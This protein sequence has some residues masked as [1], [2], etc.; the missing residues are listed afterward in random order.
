[1]TNVNDDSL[2]RDTFEPARNAEATSAQVDQVMNKLSGSTTSWR[3]RFRRSRRAR[4][5]V[6]AVFA[7][8]LIAVSPVGAAV[9]DLGSTF[10]GY[11]SDD[12]SGEEL[13]VPAADDPDAPP[14]LK[15][16]ANERLL[17][18][19]D[20]YQLYIGRQPDG[21]IAFSLDKNLTISDSPS[22]WQSQFGD[23]YILT[24]GLVASPVDEDTRSVPIY[25][26]SATGVDAVEVRYA[27]GRSTVV[28]AH[29][30]G[31]VM[32][33]E[34]ARKPSELVGLDVNGKELQVIDLT[35]FDF[36]R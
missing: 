4:I 28:D 24:F 20:G 15:E 13:G 34:P 21:T 32:S 6:A 31:F 2:V 10:A 29:A 26:L 16:Q 14:W 19:N 25:G 7:A 35:T 22:G 17:A 8:G 18:S 11:F 36:P 27:D 3:A 9:S 5:G 33:V 30:G 1:M 23:D 12:G